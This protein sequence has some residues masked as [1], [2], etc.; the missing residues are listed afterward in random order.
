MLPCDLCDSGGGYV[1]PLG[2]NTLS[3]S[4]KP[5]IPPS[6]SSGKEPL[7]VQVSSAGVLPLKTAVAIS[8]AVFAMQAIQ[9]LSF[10]QDATGAETLE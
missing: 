8:S 9:R 7:K 4:P 5:D 10:T 1:E 3:P 6:A 2:L